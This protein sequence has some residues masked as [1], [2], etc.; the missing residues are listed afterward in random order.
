V[1]V[2]A[3]DADAARRTLAGWPVERPALVTVEAPS[4]GDE[5]ATDAV[6]ALVAGLAAERSLLAGVA[7]PEGGDR[8]AAQI[9][10]SDRLRA[11][12]TVP[13]VLVDP[14]DAD[15]AATAILSGRADLCQGLPSLASTRWAPTGSS[16]IEVVAA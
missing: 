15:H 1:E 14:A 12:T 13:L 4:P 3:D 9:M 2:T 10:L 6:V 11:E 7:P 16:A 8:E 5:A